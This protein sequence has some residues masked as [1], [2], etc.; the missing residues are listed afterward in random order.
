VTGA[1]G[2]TGTTGTTGATMISAINRALHDA[3]AEDPSIVVL[4]EDVGHLG[5]VFRA[6]EGLQDRFGE[7]RCFDTPLAESAIV[8]LSVGLAI[9]GRRPVAEIQFDAFSFPAFEQ[10]VNHLAKYRN[11]TRGRVGLPVVIR[12]PYGGGIGAIELHSDSPEAYFVHT[13]GLTVVAPA[14]VADAYSLL[15]ASLRHPDPVIFLE[16]KSR[17]RHRDP[18]ALPVVTEPLGKAVVRR[19][20][21]DCTVVTYGPSLH[22]VLDAAA[23]AATEGHSVE[24]VD[25]RTLMPLD[26]E[27][28][29]ESVARTGRCVVVHEAP[30]TLGV[31]AEVAARVNEALFDRLLAP[32]LRVTGYDTPYPPARIERQW[33]PDAE[34]VLDAV[35]RTLTYPPRHSGSR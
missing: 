2:T 6:T 28:V 32:V 23:I 1:T 34:R 17:Y 4:G 14:T 26:E 21:S 20:G 12:L 35:Y 11:R 29:L 24:V 25:L 31:G 22:L 15:R 16:P 8:G 3:M 19:A 7:D 5:G 30:L 9:Q 10:I 13:P 33:L 18:V 27:T